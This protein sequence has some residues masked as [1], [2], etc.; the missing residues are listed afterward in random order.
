[1][2]EVFTAMSRINEDIRT[3]VM[4][5]STSEELG[6]L[7]HLMSYCAPKH[8]IIIAKIIDNLIR[9]NVPDKLFE[10]SMTQLLRYEDP[11]TQKI[12][13]FPTVT[14]FDSTFIQYIYNNL[15]SIRYN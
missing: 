1:M 4:K 9:M 12:M 3:I 15:M 13:D 8:R 10:E 5:V 14:K 2:I 11:L 7:L 6:S